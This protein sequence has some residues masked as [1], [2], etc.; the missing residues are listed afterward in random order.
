MNLEHVL[1]AQE[2]TKSVISIMF[3]GN[4]QKTETNRIL[5]VVSSMN[6]EMTRTSIRLIYFIVTC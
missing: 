5:S 2:I 1:L 6:L 3:T 4:S